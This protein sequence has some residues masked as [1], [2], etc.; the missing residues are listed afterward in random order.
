MS[1][2]DTEEST[3]DKPPVEDEP[4]IVIRRTEADDDD[5]VGPQGPPPASPA[6]VTVVERRS[7]SVQ[8]LSPA[9]QR[10]L[11]KGREMFRIRD[12]RPGQAEIMESVIAGRRGLDAP[13][14]RRIVELI[15]KAELDA[16]GSPGLTPEQIRG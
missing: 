10:A 3:V 11:A 7:P 8:E 4:T 12:L 1:G 5:G 14:S 16:K 13:L 9:L 6:E 15:R 2:D